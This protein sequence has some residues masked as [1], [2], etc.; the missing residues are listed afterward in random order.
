MGVDY[1]Y[2]EFGESHFI[3]HKEMCLR[4]G[5]STQT[6]I[7]KREVFDGCVFDPKV[8][9]AEDYDWGARA[10]RNHTVYFLN[11]PLVEAYLQDDSITLKGWKK[12]AETRRYFLKKYKDEFPDN[13]DLEIYHLQ[14]LARAR[15][16]IGEK[17]VEEF[18]RLY[19]LRRTPQIWIRLQL[20]RLGLMGLMY[21]LKEKD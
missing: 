16:L 1:I 19:A 4:V 12:V 21:R 7:A 15:G 14:V 18:K 11:Q 6:I 9:K 13:P 3:P 8:S 17:P 20:A 10:S 5:I 2:P